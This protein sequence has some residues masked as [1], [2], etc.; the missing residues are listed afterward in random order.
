[1]LF[2]WA[3]LAAGHSFTRELGWPLPVAPGTLIGLA[4]LTAGRVEIAWCL[5]AV[6]GVG[7][8]VALGTCLVAVM[9]ATTPAWPRVW[10]D[11]ASRP[12]MVFAAESPWTR[13]G[14]P[15]RG[16]GAEVAVRAGETQRLVLLGRGRVRVQ[17]WEGEAGSREVR[18][19]SE[20]TLRPGD[21]LVVPPGFPIRF[22]AGRSIPD[23]PAS[24][25]DWL[26]PPGP[27]PDWGGL[28]GLALTLLLGGLGMAP[29]HAALSGGRR[30][31]TIVLAPMLVVAGCI[32]LPLWTL[33][34][35]WLT[36][37]IFIGGVAAAELFE[38]P[39]LVTGLDGAQAPLAALA[40]GAHAAAGMAAILTALLAVPRDLGRAAAPVVVAAAAGL[41]A[42]VPAD[43]WRILVAAFGFAAA[44]GAPGALLASW[45]ERVSPRALAAGA[46]VGAGAFAVL[47]AL[48]L[49]PLARAG[50]ASWGAWVVAWPVVVAAPANALVVWLLS[51]PTVPSS[52]GVLSPDLAAL[53][54]EP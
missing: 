39:T 33:Y 11:V 30:R 5:A 22:E 31:G 9:L 6:A 28:G 24:G 51:P 23:A 25:P 13:E 49:V 54:D 1:L 4:A 10:T 20:V 45:S 37:E 38:L 2:L 19:D 35:L 7:A 46:V 15:V 12:R 17:L 42:A 52:R 8:S 40:K 18:A 21:R 29:V 53:H 3:Q 36:P 14:W 48:A 50:D 32:G 34:A 26:D 41:T 44:A 47:A 43:P 27:R 16:R